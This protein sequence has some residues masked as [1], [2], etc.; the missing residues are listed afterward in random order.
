[1]N[2]IRWLDKNFERIIMAV[3]MAGIVIF[4]GIDIASR[5]IFGHSPMYA[6]EAARYCMITVVFIG[7]SYGIRYNAHI[8]AEILSEVIPKA[9]GFLNVTS[10]IGMFVFGAI[11]VHAGPVKIGQLVASGQ[12]SVGTHMPMYVMY[13][14][15]EIG[16]IMCLLRIIQKYILLIVFKK[17]F[18]FDELDLKRNIDVE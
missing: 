4:M 11:L 18:A 7:L 17:G 8:K 15:L 9:R 3:F 16:W 2:V 14:V 12:I 10:D 6:Q 13:I 5:Y 1:M